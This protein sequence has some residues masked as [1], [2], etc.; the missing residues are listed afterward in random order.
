MKKWS[1][2]VDTRPRQVDTRDRSQ[3]NKS[4]GFY[5]RSTPNVVRS[6]LE[7]LPRRPVFQLA[8]TEPFRASQKP[9]L[10][11]RRV[12]LPAPALLVIPQD[13][14]H[15]SKHEKWSLIIEDATGSLQGSRSSGSNR[16]RRPQ[17]R[18]QNSECRASARDFKN[19]SPSLENT[20]IKKTSRKTPKISK[21]QNQNKTT[22]STQSPDRSTPV[23]KKKDSVAVVSTLVKERQAGEIYENL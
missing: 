18:S 5:L 7:S 13:N 20:E 15:L 10:A 17:G 6:T 12:H 11:A 3:R 9:V 8:T 16:L 4:T 22:R 14:S 1:T 19:S 21:T 23:H 2:S